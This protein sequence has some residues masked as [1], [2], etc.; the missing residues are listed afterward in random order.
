M[1]S[2][3]GPQASRQ[4]S[5]PEGSE[6]PA[7]RDVAN[8]PK[9]FTEE[10]ENPTPAVGLADRGE[11]RPSTSLRRPPPPPPGRLQ[12]RS[13]AYGAGD[14]PQRSTP[15]GTT[16]R[17]HRGECAMPPQTP[18]PEAASR[19]QGRPRS[20]KS[21]RRTLPPT[22]SEPGPSHL[23]AISIGAAAE[24]RRKPV[25]TAA[26]AGEKRAM[27]SAARPWP[28]KEQTRCRR[29]RNAKPCASAGAWAPSSGG[30]RPR[31]A[32]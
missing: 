18:N 15:A 5:L 7:S 25:P 12:P 10:L 32:N 22:E 4:P 13:G 23:E 26:G 29:Q 1:N 19:G 28:N 21:L 24:R 14:P 27:R 6:P 9:S 11:H 17:G 2:P 8:Q 30:R 20:T 3:T 31:P 16:R